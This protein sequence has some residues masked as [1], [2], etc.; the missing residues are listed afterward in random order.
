M[1]WFSKILLDS[2]EIFYKSAKCIA[3]VNIKPLVP[4]HVLVVPQRR[5]AR[6]N[7][8]SEE[9]AIDLI[10]SVQRVSRIIEKVYEATSLS[11]AIQDG[12]EAGQ[13][14]P[15]VHFHILPRR[16]NDWPRN[17]QVYEDASYH[18]LDSSINAY[19]LFVVE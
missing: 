19:Y 6:F 3:F 12:P 15:H 13:S 14:V 16:K 5:V 7:D 9:E 2:R 8:L 17:D 18:I 4:G 1:Y 11:L 10:L